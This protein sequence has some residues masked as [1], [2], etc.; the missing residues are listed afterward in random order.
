MATPSYDDQFVHKV[1][2]IDHEMLG[3]R[4]PVTF[5]TRDQDKQKRTVCEN[6]KKKRRKE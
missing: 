2:M 3:R 5:R 4:C 1:T 6:E